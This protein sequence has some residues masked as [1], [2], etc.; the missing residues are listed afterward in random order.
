[1]LFETVRNFSTGKITHQPQVDIHP[2]GFY[3]TGRIDGDEKLDW[4]QP[5]HNIFNF[6]RGICLPGPEARTFCKDVEIKI[7]RVELLPNAP[8]FKG[9]P[10]A[11]LDLYADGFFVKTADSYLRVVEWSGIDQVRIGDRLK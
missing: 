5:S 6:V 1:M 3:C 7:N 2:L 11:V 4:D 9:I 10:G 8:V